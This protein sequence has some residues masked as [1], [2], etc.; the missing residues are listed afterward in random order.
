M[1]SGTTRM[2]RGTP[3]RSHVLGPSELD[4]RWRAAQATM[5]DLYER[6]YRQYDSRAAVPDGKITVRGDQTMMGWYGYL[7]IVDRKSG[8][9]ATAGFTVYPRATHLASYEK[10]RSVEF[11]AEL[12]RSG[13]G[14]IVR[15][16]LRHRYRTAGDRKVAR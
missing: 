14:K 11:M 4:Q 8:M 7:C 16:Q 6:G 15:R 1:L 5:A 3:G 12:P 2:G 9:V 10:P 13:P